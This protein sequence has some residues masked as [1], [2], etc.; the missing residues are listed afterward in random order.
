MYWNGFGITNECCDD[1]GTN[2]K[3]SEETIDSTGL[4][5]EAAKWMRH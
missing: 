2:V 1:N 3:K 4:A 5:V